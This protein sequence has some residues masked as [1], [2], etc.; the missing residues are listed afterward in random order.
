MADKWLIFVLITLGFFWSEPAVT[1]STV[2]SITG[3][4][5]VTL[6]GSATYTIPIRI[7]PGTWGM[8][9]KLSLVYDSQAPSGPLGA[10]W[11]IAGLSAITRGPKNARFDALPDGVRMEESDA[12]YLDGQRL[13]AISTRNS[14]ATRQVEYRKETDDQTRIIETGNDLGTARFV[15][16]TKGGLRIDFDSIP[17]APSDQNRGDIRFSDGSVLLRAETRIADSAGNFID[18]YYLVNGN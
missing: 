11:S 9:P 10:G 13:V 5:D 17:G 3:S 15:V 2:G 16:N 7:A 8:E 18:F 14:G 4:F 1:Q 6:S 12:L